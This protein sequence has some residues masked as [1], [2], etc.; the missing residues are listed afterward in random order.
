MAGS[1]NYDTPA[2][3]SR[4]NASSVLPGPTPGKQNPFPP[5]TDRVI[6]DWLN[7]LNDVIADLNKA[8]AAGLNVATYM[9]RA[10]TAYQTLQRIYQAY[11]G[12][13]SGH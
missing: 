9:V 3:D 1:P 5:G 6:L 8:T 10:Q 12:Q 7:K 11:F 2:Y 4:G 13:I